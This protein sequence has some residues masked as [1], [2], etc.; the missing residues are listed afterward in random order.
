ME[1][2]KSSSAL[3][4]TNRDLKRFRISENIEK[5]RP[6]GIYLAPESINGH[7]NLKTTTKFF[8]MEAHKRNF[9]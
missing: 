5:L 1:L 8:H 3:K 6:G 7:Q 9:A 2:T 4:L